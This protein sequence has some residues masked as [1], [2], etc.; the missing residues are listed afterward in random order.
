M[1][2]FPFSPIWYLRASSVTELCSSCFILET[3]SPLFVQ[4]CSHHLFSFFGTSVTWI[5]VSHNCI[6][7]CF[8]SF[9]LLG[10]YLSL[11][12]IP[13]IYKFSLS[14]LLCFLYSLHLMFLHCVLFSSFALEY[15]YYCKKFKS[16]IFCIL[17]AFDIISRPV[18]FSSMK[19]SWSSDIL[20]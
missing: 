7:W 10:D 20:F 18:C 9:F 16:W 6:F 5:L 8:V 13:R 15:F 3:L 1:P 17:S 14:H 11:L 12:F 19:H 4:L 2:V